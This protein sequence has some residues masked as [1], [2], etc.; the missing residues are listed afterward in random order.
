MTQVP[1]PHLSPD[2]VESWL[3]R[4]PRRRT[5]PTSRPVPGL[6][7]SRAGGARDRRAASGAAAV[8]PLRRSSPTG[9]WRRSSWPIRSRSARSQPFGSG[10]SPP[11]ARIAIAAEP[12][13]RP[14]RLDGRQRRVDARQPGHARHRRQLG[15][16]RRARRPAG[17]P[18]AAWRP[19]SSSSRGTRAREPWSVNPGRLAARDRRRVPGVP[20]RDLALRRLL[21]LPTQQV[22]HV[23]HLAA[24]LAP[25]AAAAPC[26]VA[27]DG[28]R[29]RPPVGTH[30]LR[31]GRA[32]RNFWDLDRRASRVR[33]AAGRDPSRRPFRRCPRYSAGR[34]ERSLQAQRSREPTSR[35]RFAPDDG[36][37]PGHRARR[38]RAAGQLHRRLRRD[39][40]GQS[41]RG[42]GRCRHLRPL[43]R[44]SGDGRR[45]CHRA[46]RRP[47]LGRRPRPGRRGARPRWRDRRRDPGASVQHRASRPPP[48]RAT[49]AAAP[50]LETVV[51]AARGRH[52]RLPHAWRARV[53]PGDVRP[54]EPRSGVR[55]G[56]AF[57][58]AGVRHRAC[59]VRSW[60]CPPSAC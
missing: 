33:I 24:A 58:R 4:H 17:S 28:R 21:A 7:R 59:W 13:A 11:G 54:A 27:L 39:A 16:G 40:G 44:Q 45:R 34:P 60:C 41:A 1:G 52:G 36:A 26:L 38:H 53:R 46:P 51:A 23:G 8:D 9:S 12:R 57:V 2:D 20:R 14:G 48:S 32:G 50:V 15:A 49:G 5:H 10:S 29:R 18:C 47:G 56:L 19:T 35:P 42:P 3:E 55:Y 25:L 30:R 37:D 31:G 22:A 6:S 43:A